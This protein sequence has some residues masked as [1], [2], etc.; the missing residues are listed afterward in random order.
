MPILTAEPDL[1]PGNLFDRPDLGTE[2]DNRWWALYTMSRRE[3]ELMRQ[4]RGLDVP[5]YGPVVA[6]RQK[7]PNG[8]LRTSFLPLFSSY[9]FFYGDHEL[10]HKALTTNC[11]SR[12]IE[13]VDGQGLTH[14]LKQIRHLIISGA[15]VTIEAR[16]QPGMRVRV[17]TGMLQ[18][19]EGMIIRRQGETRLLVAV[20][21]LQQGAS[22]LLDDIAV[23][24]ID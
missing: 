21:F 12:C 15:A 6:K 22:V 8:R 9:V 16:L 13:V 20:N 23:E 5:H 19:Q 18:G 11:I 24:Q 17:K 10:R 14:D 1:Y 3:K 7:G 4:L 2:S